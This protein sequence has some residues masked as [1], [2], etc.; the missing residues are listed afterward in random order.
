MEGCDAV[1][2]FAAETH[3]DRSLPA[4]GSFIETDV[5][6]RPCSSRR[7]A[8]GR[9]AIR[10][11]L[12]RRGLRLDRDGLVHGGVAASSRA[13]RTRRP[14]RAATGSR[15]RTGRPTALPVSSRAARTT[16]GRTST[17]RSSSRSSSRTRSTASRCR[18]TATGCNVR[19]WLYV[20][21]H[22]RAIDF[23]LEASARARRTTSA[24]GNER[25]N[26]EITDVVLRALE[27]P[28][29]LI[30]FVD[31][32]P[33]TTGATRSTPQARAPRLRAREC[34]SRTASSRRSAG[35]ATHRAWWER[36]KSGEAFREWREQWY[37]ARE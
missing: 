31:D 36:I 33:G 1:V 29:T 16:T 23:L 7:R 14:R 24:A 9:R 37:A 27:Q 6:A 26:L 35:I 20:E 3:V 21:D 19:D 4:A 8:D 30:R 32:R 22:C 34:R 17:R 25:T 10:P 5:A 18:S 15:S 28:E 12:D 13:T 11:D 2:N